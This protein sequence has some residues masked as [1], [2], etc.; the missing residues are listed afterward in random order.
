[1][2]ILAKIFGPIV[3]DATINLDQINIIAFDTDGTLVH[4]EKD[5]FVL[6][7]CTPDANIV[8]LLRDLTENK[9][10]LGLEEVVIISGNIAHAQNLL[11]KAEIS[12]Q[13]ANRVEDRINF[14]SRVRGKNKNVLV[15]DDDMMLALEAQAYV[16]P[17]SR[18]VQ[19]YLS[20]KSYR[21]A[22]GIA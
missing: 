12:S 7:R 13:I 15:V 17:N 8:R 3:A 22:L 9:D 11:Q 16:N 1:M 5:G 18:S 4:T 2:G 21:Q 14:Y 20:T 6:R 19:E 10:R